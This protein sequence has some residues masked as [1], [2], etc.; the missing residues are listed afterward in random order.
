VTW[1]GPANPLLRQSVADLSNS[2]SVCLEPHARDCQFYQ[3]NFDGDVVAR[4]LDELRETLDKAPKRAPWSAYLR[5]NFVA[6][7]ETIS[8]QPADWEAI[9][10]WAEKKGY[11]G[12]GGIKPATAK[13]A[14]ERERERREGKP[15]K[16]AAPAPMP[17][18][19]PARGVQLM[20]AAPKPA[21]PWKY[22]KKVTP[23][24]ED[25]ISKSLDAGRGWLPRSGSR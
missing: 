13:R 19:A 18:R 4:D 20:P 24:E 14:Y 1:C 5:R 8:D 11:T 17:A 3:R 10:A 2:V 22:P 25:D 23:S 21:E 12:E 6:F 15:P 7:R 9:A 16:K